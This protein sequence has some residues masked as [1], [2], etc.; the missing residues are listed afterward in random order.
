MLLGNGFTTNDVLAELL[1]QE[2]PPVV[3]VKV[4]GEPEP[5][6]VYVVTP[7]VRP[8]VLSD[9]KVPPAP[10][11]FHTADVAPPP[12]E[13]PKG[14]VVL[15]WHTA[16]TVVTATVGLGFTVNVMLQET[17]PQEPTVLV[18]VKVTVAGAE[19]DAV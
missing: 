8:V 6:A 1:P 11:S 18:S 4:T 5:D 16:A 19:D 3:S 10:P 14:P 12:N 17:V 9:E 13:P 2:P 7:G 15:P